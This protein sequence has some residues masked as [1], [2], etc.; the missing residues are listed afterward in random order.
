MKSEYDIFAAFLRLK[1]LKFTPERRQILEAVFSIHNHFE[2]DELLV[3]IHQTYKKH[4]SK[5]TIYRSLPL[6]VECG[7]IREVIFIDKHMHYEH[8]FG[9]TEHEHLICVK[10]RKIVEFTDASFKSALEEIAKKYNFRKLGHKL[11]IDGLCESC[12]H[13]RGITDE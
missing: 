13:P 6:L 3:K 10:C 4:V 1:E 2:V 11:E 8:V 12:S 5:A 9:H 7:L